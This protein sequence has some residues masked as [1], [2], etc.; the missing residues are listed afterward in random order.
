MLLTQ[1]LAANPAVL[2]AFTAFLGLAVGSFLNVVIHRL[3]QMMERDWRR[4]CAEMLNDSGAEATG[5]DRVAAE[6]F[7]LVIP[8]SRCPGCGHQIAALENIPV[9]S[10]I[11]LRGRCSACGAR[12][13]LRYPAVELLTAALS[14]VV[15]WHFGV[16]PQAA[17]ALLL[18]WALVALSFIDFD[19]QLL[20]DSITMP[21][22]WLGIVFNLGGV[23]T[24]L[25]SS[26]IGAIAGY[27]LLWLVYHAFRLLTG[28]EGMGFGDF[29]LL[30]LLG[31]WLGWQLLPVIV[32]L[33]SLVGAV[34]GVSMIALRG[35][36]RNVPIP[37]GPYLAI[38]GWVAMIWGHAIMRAYLDSSGLSG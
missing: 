2:Y 10:Y 9:V 5:R 8:R 23:Y 26:V 19:T 1:F 11:A 21:F 29:K 35:H 3:P 6:R 17:G 14:L 27:G 37:F 12:I 25:E 30:G 38:A 13:S 24:S 28:K 7:D 18:T 32:L 15:V 22:L 33:S 36:D 4:H 34:V 31:A 20:P 16:S